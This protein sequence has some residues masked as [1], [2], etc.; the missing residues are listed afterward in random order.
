LC[1]FSGQVFF[2]RHLST[3]IETQQPNTPSGT[4]L[5]LLVK[6]TEL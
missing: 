4:S 3:D 2:M 6:H 1:K 5:M